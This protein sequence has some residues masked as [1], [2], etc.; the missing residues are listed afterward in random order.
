MLK[1]FRT[2]SLLATTIIAGF[3]VTVPAHAQDMSAPP[4]AD[5]SDGTASPA[6]AT[7]P[8]GA[9]TPG[10][11][12]A[13]TT[14]N[15]GPGVQPQQAV[16][17]AQGSGGEIIV[18]GTLIRNPNLTS[19][20][21]VA[22]VGSQEISLRQP[23]SA[24]EVIR[25][26]PGV[27]PALG[28]NVNNGATGQA[29]V[30]LRGLG[31]KRNLVMLDSTRLVPARELGLFDLK[32]IPVALI[33]RVDVLTGGASTTYGADA[34][35]GVVNFIT[36]K[37][38]A[39]VDLRLGEGIT[40]EGDGNT[41]RADL[42]LG[43]NFDDGHGNA[44]LSVSYVESDPVYF[45]DRLIGQCVVNS[46]TGFCG[47]DSATST[48]TALQFT[49]DQN[50]LIGQPAGN[51]Q[52]PVG[53]VGGLVPQYAFFNFNPFNLYQTPFKR[54]NAFGQAHYDI[55]DSIS[56]YG[57]ALFSKNYTS[58]IVAPSGVF[59]EEL[60]VPGFNPFLTP[61]IR[62]QLCTINGVALGTACE[63]APALAL[64]YVYRRTVEVG[65]RIDEQ[66]TNFFDFKAGATWNITPSIAFDLYGA[67]GESEVQQRRRN[68]VLRS[69]LQ[70]ALDV[71]PNN[72]AACAD[73]SGGC[74]PLNLFGPPGSITPEMARFIGGTE[75]TINRGATLAQVHA[76]LSGDFGWSTP[77]ATRPIAFALGAE[78]R[79]YTAH[80]R[81][82]FLAAIPGQLGGAGGALLPIEGGLTA[83]DAFAEL[84]VPIASDRPFFNELQL[85]GGFR[86]SHYVID[87]PGKP[88][89][90]ANTYKIG[91]TWAPIPEVKFRG[92]YQ[93]AVRAP[94]IA[95]LF[96]P[97]VTGLT[98]LGNDPCAGAQTAAQVTTTN[99]L[100]PHLSDP[101]FVAV[102]LAQGAPAGSIGTIPQPTSNQANATGGGNPFLKPETSHSWTVGVVLNPR[103]LLPGFNATLDYY[104]IKIKDSINAPVPGAVIDACFAN[105]TAASATSPAC[106]A[107]HRNLKSGG[108][109]GSTANVQGLPVPFSN[110][111]HLETDGFDLTA[112]YRHGLG[113]MGA[114]LIL[115][116]N[117][118]YTRHAKFFASDTTTTAPNCPGLYGADCGIAIGQLQPK[119]SWNQ[120]TTLSF[121]PVDISLLWRHLSSFSYEFASDPDP[122][123]HLCQVAQG[124]TGEIRGGPFAGKKFNP[125]HIPAFDYFDLS[126][127]FSITDHYELTLSA[128]NIFNKQAPIVG[129]QAGTTS[130]G[131]G[132]TFPS[133]YDALGRR[134]AAT[135]RLKF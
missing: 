114:D 11:T 53:G 84:I 37:N 97:V 20:S 49:A 27:T 125:N 90:S 77:W 38:F 8:G 71:D 89:F 99:P 54:Y 118:N 101:N 135:V 94:N 46:F 26:I 86:R 10:E 95:E 82:D 116:F 44:V 127:R 111:G 88:K 120:R 6:D 5:T 124:C 108:L 36:K 19:S 21:P 92:N 78:H 51:L 76:V 41:F 42:T 63:T 1:G 17:P 68:Y 25:T 69:T 4:P 73:T 126:T 18:T 47:G 62:D 66:N 45:G 80:V 24:E 106:T 75:S 133:T 134:Y 104:N 119:W 122:A 105:I 14:A 110:A 3:S 16:P 128:F 109:S 34:V 12:Q 72:P 15:T 129:N 70:Q 35:T 33:D 7:A 115:N 59:G 57:R 112:N 23:T 13:G 2:G 52:I 93:Q 83:E 123:N 132:N 48:P 39:G 32:N 131:S 102:C 50:A 22:V 58:S 74:V 96:A 130:A 55:S 28:Q 64:G 65:P 100:N 107:I 56:V 67:Y 9:T 30:D 87:A 113:W 121:K 79:D 31:A 60:T 61:T 40:E 117:G 98:T 43:A 29:T 103:S 81:P 85:E 91:G